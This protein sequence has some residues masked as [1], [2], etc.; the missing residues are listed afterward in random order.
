[1]PQLKIIAILQ[2]EFIFFWQILKI[3]NWW[4]FRISSLF[5]ALQ[6][7]NKSFFRTICL[8]GVQAA[9]PHGEK[10]AR[11]SALDPVRLGATLAHQ[12]TTHNTEHRRASQGLQGLWYYSIFFFFLVS[13]HFAQG[14][15]GEFCGPSFW[16]LVGQSAQIRSFYP[17]TVGNW[18]EGGGGDIPRNSSWN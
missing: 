14:Q 10:W 13:F 6:R 7:N 16:L 9:G 11:Q 3:L 4:R 5:T 15:T 17:K 2:P 12:A 8:S 18:G 1:M